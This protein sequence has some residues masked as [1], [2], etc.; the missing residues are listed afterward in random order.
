MKILSCEM[1]I[2]DLLLV[3]NSKQVH[4]LIQ[5]GQRCNTIILNGFFWAKLKQLKGEQLLKVLET[6]DG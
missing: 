3:T 4:L 5:S 2:K 1:E 6:E